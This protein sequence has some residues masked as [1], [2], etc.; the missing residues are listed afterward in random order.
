M[1]ANLIEEI[2]TVTLLG[3]MNGNQKIPEMD[4]LVR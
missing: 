4:H 3:E 1:K 2:G